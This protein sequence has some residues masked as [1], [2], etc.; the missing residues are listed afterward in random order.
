MRPKFAP[1]AEKKFTESR[2]ETHQPTY[3]VNLIPRDDKHVVRTI[4]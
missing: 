4:R 2:E 3:V 1:P